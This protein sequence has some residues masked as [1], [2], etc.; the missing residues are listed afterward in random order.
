MISPT[1]VFFCMGHDGHFR[2]LRPLIETVA[3]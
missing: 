2:R 3:A 1:V